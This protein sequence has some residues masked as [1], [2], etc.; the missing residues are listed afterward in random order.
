M[1]TLFSN[2]KAE[3]EARFGYASAERIETR[4][5]GFDFFSFSITLFA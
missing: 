4:W 5:R 3:A 1:Q 2:P